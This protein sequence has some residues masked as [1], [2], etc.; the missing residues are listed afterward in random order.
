[1]RIALT[2]HKFPPESLGGTE[3]YTWGL[4]KA[5]V[6]AGHTVS[7][8]YPQP[9]VTADEARVERDGI[10]L[11]R[12]PIP[13]GRATEDPVRQFWH[14][15][16]D[17]DIDEAFRAFLVETDPEIIH[18]Q[19]VQGVSAQLIGLA[20]G[21]PRVL[22]LHDYWFFCA[23]SQLIRPD[24]QTCAGPRLGWNCVDCATA[25]ADLH[26]LRAL[27][28]LVA[29]PLAYRNLYLSGQARQVDLFIAP[30]EFLRQQYVRQGFPVD[31]IVTI[32]N[33]TDAG[34]LAGPG[35]P[36]IPHDAEHVQF[37][38]LGSLAWQKGVHVL[39]EAF[40]HL[41]SRARLVIYGGDRAFPEYAAE[42]RVLAQHPGIRFAGALDYRQIGEALRALDCLVVP[43]LWY[44]NSPLVIQEAFSVG[45]P[46]VA[47][48][49]GALIE[50]VDDRRTGRLFEPGSVDDLAHVLSE[51]VEH[52]AELGKLA[53]NTVPPPTM[54]SHAE[55]LVRLYGGLLRKTPPP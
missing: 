40:N 53:R 14:T 23:N 29:L 2:V 50:K 34:R 4:A 43:S 8:F 24:R 52:P 48:R 42:V 19:H 39:V 41:P 26:R 35:R 16:R 51:L 30:S 37:G 36:R 25:R 9:G 11:W 1:M 32:E 17:K 47:S 21:R 28:P 7:V 6:A 22:T 3:I 45:V 44:E 49:L 33:G 15:F 20:A 18:F 12:T 5:L 27:R 31:R 55:E 46:V 13:A 54:E 10:R 38:F